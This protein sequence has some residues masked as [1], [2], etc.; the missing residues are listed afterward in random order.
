MA[1]TPGAM[2]DYVRDHFAEFRGFVHKEIKTITDPLRETLEEIKAWQVTL[3][4]GDQLTR[5]EAEAVVLKMTEEKS[6]VEAA[7]IEIATTIENNNMQHVEN[8]RAAGEMAKE[9]MDAQAIQI[10]SLSEKLAELEA[11]QAATT[12][13]VDKNQERDSSGP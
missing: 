4:V 13:I 6:A 12:E 10:K 2:E 9:L 11:A 1:V 3:S 8:M 5:A 7:R